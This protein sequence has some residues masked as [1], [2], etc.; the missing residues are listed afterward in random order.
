VIGND[1]IRPPAFLHIRWH[2]ELVRVDKAG[3]YLIGPIELC[4]GPQLILVEEALHQGAV[5]LF[6]DA[7]ILP[8]NTVGDEGPMR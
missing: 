1:P 5:D 7:A 8:I 3:Y 6:T 4:N 2:I